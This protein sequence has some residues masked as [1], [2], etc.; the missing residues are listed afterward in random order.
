ML[1]LATQLQIFDYSVDQHS[2]TVLA[3][4]S[5][6]THSRRSSVRCI[7]VV[8]NWM[9][10]N[11]L[12][13]NLEKTEVFWCTTGRRQHQLPSTTALSI[14]GVPFSSVTSFKNLGIFIH[15]DLVMRTQVQQ[16]GLGRCAPSTT[17][18]LQLRAGGHV[19]VAQVVTQVISR[20]DYGNGV[21][22]GLSTHLVRRFQ[23]VQNAAARL[24]F[25]LR[26]FDHITDDLVSLHWLR[27]SE[28]VVNK[29]AVMMFRVQ[30]GIAPEYLGP[31][32]RVANL[33]GRRALRS[34]GTNRLHGGATV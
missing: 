3:K 14:D 23:S 20:L 6:S 33:P 30:H 16:I 9:R 12:Q 15:S 21:P 5:R 4:P 22:I 17:S 32:V 10:S 2:C 25:K 26:R 24:I 34:S 7:G 11:R 31:V 13:L 1:E 27:V 18:D 8:F 28:R 29:I 19:P